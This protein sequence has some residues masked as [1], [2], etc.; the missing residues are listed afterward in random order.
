MDAAGQLAQ[1][2]ERVGELL[3]RGAEQ[4]LRRGGVLVQAALRE[5]ERQGEGDEPLLG[6]V[7]QVALE[8]P[9][10]G[11]AGLHQPRAR[12]VQLLHAG[13][14]LRLEPLVLQ[15][16]PGRA[17]H[18]GQQ[19]GVVAQVARVQDGADAAAV[20]ADLRGGAHAGRPSAGSSTE[21][22]CASTQ[23]E[24]SSSR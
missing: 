11:R 8:P 17:R 4:A 20:A 3:L 21:R 24:P 15:R 18:G 12:G 14:E 22:P 9:A 5:A 19:A 1:L 13:A 6:A 23:R 10:L 2:L 16:Q 7:V